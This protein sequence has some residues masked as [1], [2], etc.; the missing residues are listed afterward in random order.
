MLNK[1]AFQEDDRYAKFGIAIP[2]VTLKFTVV[3]AQGSF[4]QKGN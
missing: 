4:N 2:Q 1:N 3:A